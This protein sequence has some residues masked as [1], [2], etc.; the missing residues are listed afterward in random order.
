MKRK[1]QKSDEI[2]FNI[3]KIIGATFVILAL[4]IASIFL[5]FNSNKEKEKQNNALKEANQELKKSNENKEDIIQRLDSNNV[6]KEQKKTRKIGEKFIK[7]MFINDPKKLITDKH[8]DATK[9]MTNKLA[10]KYYGKKDPMPNRYE[11]DIKNLNIYDDRYS[12]AKEN[13][14]MF[15]TFKQLS[16]EPDDSISMQQDIV[17]ELD[18]KQTD[19]GWRVEKF[20]QIAG[21]DNR[22]K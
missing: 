8:D 19:D 13:Y 3:N 7:I 20:K 9:V 16:K 4:A 17:I 22:S 2:K 1:K 21:Q 11:T 6:D 18:L 5:I 14:K 15:A 12:P 10:D